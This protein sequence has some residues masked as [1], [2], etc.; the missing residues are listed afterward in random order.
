MGALSRSDIETCGSGNRLSAAALMFQSCQSRKR[1][2]GRL[3]S[4]QVCAR[5]F[6]APNDAGPWRSC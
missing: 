5:A 3:G 4:D 2:T 6:D 1:S